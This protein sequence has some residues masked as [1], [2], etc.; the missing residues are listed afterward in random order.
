MT[1][2]SSTPRKVRGYL[3]YFYA[4]KLNPIPYAP[5][6]PCSNPLKKPFKEPPYT[7]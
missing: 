3:L 2:E 6:L 5:Y 1:Q 7:L 4:P